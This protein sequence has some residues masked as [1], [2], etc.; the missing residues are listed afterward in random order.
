MNRAA[1]ASLIQTTQNEEWQGSNKKHQVLSYRGDHLEDL[2]DE[3]ELSSRVLKI[4]MARQQNKL[5]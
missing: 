4:A 5:R 3:P 2:E 1:T